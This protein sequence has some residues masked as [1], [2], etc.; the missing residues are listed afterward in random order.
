MTPDWDKL[1]QETPIIA[2]LV[3][4]LARRTRCSPEAVLD[5]VAELF[6]QEQ[7]AQPLRVV[8]DDP[9]AAA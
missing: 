3:V 4:G 8:G 6:E 9:Q 2:A 1:A 5:A 7:P